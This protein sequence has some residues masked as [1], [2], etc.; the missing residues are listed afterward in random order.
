MFSEDRLTRKEKKYLQLLQKTKNLHTS[1]ETPGSHF[2]C[3]SPFAFTLT[4]IEHF[5][6]KTEV[7]DEQHQ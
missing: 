4:M 3:S 2:Y 7:D 1:T 6:F 5:S